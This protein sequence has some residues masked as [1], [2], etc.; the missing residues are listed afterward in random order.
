MGADSAQGVKFEE[1]ARR[2][3]AAALTAGLTERELLV[4][5]S[6]Y[7]TQTSAVI[8][9]GEQLVFTMFGGGSQRL[10]LPLPGFTGYMIAECNFPRARGF[11][12]LSD[13]GA[14]KVA[15]GYVAEIL[16]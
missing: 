9:P 7:K 3:R 13:L 6:I 10:I 2:I 5:E 16:P 4:K 15:A 8:G 1:R 14:E 12:F 11:A